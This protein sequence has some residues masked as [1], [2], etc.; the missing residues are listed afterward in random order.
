VRDSTRVSIGRGAVNDAGSHNGLHQDVPRRKCEILVEL[1]PLNMGMD[2]GFRK[3]ARSHRDFRVKAI[4]VDSISE[5]QHN[6]CRKN[7]VHDPLKTERN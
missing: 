4:E 2:S 7:A 3:V 1:C 6:S 5:M